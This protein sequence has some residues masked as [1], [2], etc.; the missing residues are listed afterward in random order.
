MPG[1]FIL[2]SGPSL[3]TSCKGKTAVFAQEEKASLI[4]SQDGSL[5]LVFMYRLK[6]SREN[7][8]AELY[9]PFDVSLS[10]VPALSQAGDGFPSAGYRSRFSI[11]GRVGS[12]LGRA[13]VRD[14]VGEARKCGERG[15]PQ[16]SPEGD[17]VKL[18][19][20]RPGCAILG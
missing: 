19:A 17:G 9:Q 4:I 10:W 12:L 16:R 14:G 15:E 6:A 3:R 8:G 7:S 13:H 5:P 11:G 1:V 20:L 18:S 2:P